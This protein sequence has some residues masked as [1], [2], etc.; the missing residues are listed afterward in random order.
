MPRFIKFKTAS[1]GKVAGSLILI[2]KQKQDIVRIRVLSYDKDILEETECK[3]FDEAYNFIDPERMTW[4]N[5]DGLHDPDVISHIGSRFD[6][7][8][9][10]LEDIMNTDHRP[11]FEEFEDHL[12]VTLK[13][14]MF[15]KEEEG[16]D[17][18]QFS[19]IIGD[20]YVITF[21]E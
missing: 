9:L 16:L 20:H 1:K 19:M 21:Q 6:V 4:I 5:I 15:D 10:L 7:S 8:S 18:E 3:T 12:Y 14:L 2:G 13:L 11:K 17:S